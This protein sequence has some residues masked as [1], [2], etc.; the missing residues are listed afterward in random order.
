MKTKT[1]LL[2]L[3]IV[4]GSCGKKNEDQSLHITVVEYGTQKAIP[5][6]GIMVYDYESIEGR[7]GGRDVYYDSVVTDNQGRALLNGVEHEPKMIRLYTHDTSYYD[8]WPGGGNGEFYVPKVRS[9]GGIVELIPFAW[10]KIRF[11]KESDLDYIGTNRFAGELSGFDIYSKDTIVIG[12]MLGNQWN[13]ITLY[14]YENGQ[15][16]PVKH[17][18]IYPLSHDTTLHEIRW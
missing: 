6:V 14:P 11:T 7:W 10:A 1:I 8:Q 9:N 2:S 16:L 4:I 12:Q 3:I 17:D 18:S 15:A 5:D 13:V